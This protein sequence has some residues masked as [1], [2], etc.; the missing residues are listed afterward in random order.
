MSE[1]KLEI[2]QVVDYPRCR[3][4]RQ[5]IQ[6]LIKDPNIRTGGSSGLFYYT[7][8]CGY[9][10][11]R[12][13]YK[14]I[15]GISYTVYPGEWI[16]RISELKNWFRTRTVKQALCIIKDLQERHMLKYSIL[17][18]GKLV[19]YK[20]ENWAK[21]NRVLDYNAPCQKE[22][23]F[24]FL[25]VSTANELVSGG[26]CSEADAV[27]DLWINTVYNDEQV[28]GSEVGPIVYIRNGTGNP[29]LSF[30]TLA[31][32]WGVSKATAG[33]YI[34]KL[35][36][37]DYIMTVSFNGSR[38]SAVYVK[39]Y[40]STMFEISDILLDKEELAMALNIKLNIDEEKEEKTRLPQ[41][42]TVSK[43][44][45]GVSNLQIEA[46]TEKVGKILSLQGFPCFSCPKIQ[47]MLLPLSDCRDTDI[48]PI[49]SAR[50]NRARFLLIVRC[51][52]KEIFRFDIK[53][54]KEE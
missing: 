7:V 30:E 20:I 2:K 26:K 19:K 48:L 46:V 50:K 24:F 25:P 52:Q 18:H 34:N 3:I 23:G 12:S 16:C 13:S 21:S 6:C 44:L 37:L 5:L 39:R 32:R 29:L 40:L 28:K 27:L 4:Y 31:E 1:Y 35:K 33:R 53:L 8:L 49:A 22:T 11:F 51:S 47:Y 45:N 15:D 42:I 43:Y 9:A 17:G 10:N 41:N 38:G 54:E 14:R 36:A